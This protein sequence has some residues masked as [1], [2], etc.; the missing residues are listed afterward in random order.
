MPGVLQLGRDGSLTLHRDRLAQ[1]PEVLPLPLVAEAV[2][3][4]GVGLV[5]VEVFLIDREDGESPAP[6]SLCPTETPG[7]AG[8]PA[9]ITFQPGATRWTQ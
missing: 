8:S 9:P 3:G 1:H 2:R 7:S 6:R 4:R 5:D